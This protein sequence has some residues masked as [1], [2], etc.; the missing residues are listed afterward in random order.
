M[1]SRAAAIFAAHPLPRTTQG[2]AVGRATNRGFASLVHLWTRDAQAVS[3]A[4]TTR[5]ARSRAMVDPAAVM[6]A[7]T[8]PG[9]VGHG[10][11]LRAAMSHAVTV[12]A[13]V[14]IRAAAMSGSR[15]HA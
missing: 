11:I 10:V 8:N 7:V 6:C 12:R 15:R 5:A 14:T 4:A 2:N 3:H 13:A 1:R 9:V